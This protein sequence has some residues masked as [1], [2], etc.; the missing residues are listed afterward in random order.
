MRLTGVLLILSVVG[1]FL[2]FTILLFGLGFLDQSPDVALS[3]Y[4]QQSITVLLSFYGY[5]WDGLLL[6][7]AVLLLYH[8]L[9]RWGQQSLVLKIATGCGV[10]G[11]MMQTVGD[12]RWPFLLPSLDAAYFDPHAT[13]ATRDAVAVVFQAVEQIG[14]VGLSEHLSF[15]LVGAWSLLLGWSIVRSSSF[16]RWIGWVGMVGGCFF[17]LGSIEQFNLPGITDALKPVLLLAHILWGVLLLALAVNLFF[18]HIPASTK[19]ALVQ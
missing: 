13:Q 10:L 14:G 4:H 5:V 9:Q 2:P 11:G 18:Y 7:L 16:A 17:F 6:S 3:I 15:L 1:F 12:I 8:V 19:N